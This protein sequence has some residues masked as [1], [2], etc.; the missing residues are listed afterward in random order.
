MCILKK[1][2][3]IFIYLSERGIFG[4]NLKSYF[5]KYWKRNIFLQALRQFKEL[6][7]LFLKYLI[8]INFINT[9]TSMVIT[10]VKK[11]TT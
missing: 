9:S 5:D 1:T 3:E 7:Y 11:Q 6:V 8:V 10:K 4:V 2:L